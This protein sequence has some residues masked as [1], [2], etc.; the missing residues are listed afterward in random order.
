MKNFKITSL[1]ILL[2]VGL[3]V[4][5]QPVQAQLTTT[6]TTLSS[7]IAAN[8]NTEWCIASATGA[9]VPNIGQAGSY[10]VVDKEAVQIVRAGTSSTC[11]VVRRGQLGTSANAAHSSGATVWVGLPAPSSGDSSRPFTG[12][13]IA[14]AP[15]G[16]CTRTAQYSLPVIVTGLAPGNA[17]SGSQWD[18]VNGQWSNITPIGNLTI[19]GGTQ[20]AAATA[21]VATGTFTVSGGTGGAQSATTGNGAAGAAIS[22]TGGTGGA[23]GSSSGTGGAGGAVT[24]AGGVGGG[25]VT[26]GT[27]G[28]TTISSGA[29]GAGS[30]AGGSGGILLLQSGAAGTGGTGAAGAVQIK[31]GTTVLYNT[32]VG[33]TGGITSAYFCGATSGTTTCP[34]TATAGTARVI[35]GIATLSSNSA[36]ISAI[37]PAFT[38]TATFSCVAN[39]ITTRANPVQVVQTSSS[40]I[41]ITNTTGA[42][43]VI[44][45]VCIGY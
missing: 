17:L 44:N 41:T 34:N 16:S 39:D 29:G 31:A 15:S 28:A 25:T 19:T 27:G 45:W 21:I 26:G 3:L 36:V 42:S 2:A 14:G 40:S 9:T 38:S 10:L 43:D 4:V 1:L 13:F 37:S 12:V 20:P 5:P 35:G 23:G 33:G 24:I 32:A 6:S 18:C 22:E 30:G 8:T 7:A 11:F